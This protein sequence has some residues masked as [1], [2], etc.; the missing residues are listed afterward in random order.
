MSMLRWICS[1]TKRDHVRN[2]DIHEKLGVT[3]IE[4]K[5]VQHHLRWLENIQ[6]RPAS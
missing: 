2:G 1:H 6:R 4:E 5:L 3:P